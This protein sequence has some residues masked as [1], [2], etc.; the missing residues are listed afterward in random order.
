MN[1]FAKREELHQFV[2]QFIEQINYKAS[3]QQKVQDLLTCICHYF[4]YERGF[5]YQTD[6]F[7]FF[8]LKETVGNED[9]YFRSKFEKEEILADCH[10]RM[11]ECAQF[12]IADEGDSRRRECLRFHGANTL[13]MYPIKDKDEKTVAFLG[14]ANLEGGPLSV[15]ERSALR[16]VSG[17]LGKEVLLRE[18]EERE[19][20]T[21]R[22]LESI[23]NNLGVD[24]YVNSFDSHEML[25]ANE[26]MAK[27]YGGIECFI[28]DGKKCWQVL[29][30]GKTG[31]CE[32]C[33]RAHLI[34]EHGY[35]SKVYSWDYQ[36]PFDKSWFRVF[37]SAFDWIDGQLAH[38]ITSVDITHQKQIEEQLRE[39]K[40]RAEELDRL[41]SAFLANMSH[42]IRT[43]LNAIVGFSALLADTSNPM[44]QEEYLAIIN[45][46]N[47]LLLQLIGDI[48]DLSKIEANT[49]EF[50]HTI[51][52]LNAMLR[53]QEM[54]YQRKVTDDSDSKGAKEVEILFSP[55]LERCYVY[56]EKNRLMQVVNNL[57]NN[58]LKF[59]PEGH[60]HFG[61]ELRGE[62]LYFF[63]TDTGRGISEENQKRV[64][65]RFVKLNAFVKGTGL[66]LSI[67]QTII[68][69]LGGQI[70]LESEEGKGSTFWFTLPSSIMRS[71][72]ESD[73]PEPDLFL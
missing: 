12:F 60:I 30:E 63:V 33:P 15:D 29:Y 34:D 66:G 71:D 61:Y 23:M 43:P 64:F 20:R 9:H 1:T 46:N 53:H 48:L 58:A 27:P 32:F 56:T 16:A 4:G 24:I 52:D 36:R 2:S 65:Q 73:M 3:G 39:A 55:G 40:E 72:E 14:F 17:L 44:D 59:T 45:Q 38:V 13:A 68:E 51:F 28:G 50:V 22:T 69:K 31:E 7:R 35:P 10:C 62:E 5:V 25:Y 67:C 54:S 18:C 42:E 47:E 6:G 26:S 37:S 21:K 41:K 11:E 19:I 8:Y 57:L 70:G 49:L